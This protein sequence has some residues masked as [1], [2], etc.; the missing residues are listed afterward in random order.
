V[1]YATVDDVAVALGRPTSDLT[2]EETAQFGR[3][4]N[5]VEGRI[6]RR[7]PDVG[8]LAADPTYAGTLNGVIVDVVVR[9]V[10]NPD[11][12]VSERID[13]YDY[14]RNE[15]MGEA[16][17]WPTAAEWAELLPASSSEAFSTRPGFE[18]DRGPIFPE[19]WS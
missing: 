3:W 5:R 10:L 9:R 13:D 12:K 16:D 14:R 11:G 15:A 2:P 19:V 8:T 1:I 17:L 4:I 7:I 18:P 6:A